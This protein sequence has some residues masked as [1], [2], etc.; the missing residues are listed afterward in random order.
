MLIAYGR[1]E[2]MKNVKA[3]VLLFVLVVFCL[4]ISNSAVAQYTVGVKSGNW[5]KYNVSSTYSG[6]TT[7]SGWITITIQSVSGSIISGTIEGSVPGYST[8]PQPFTVN[9]ETGSTT[10]SLPAFMFIP[11]NLNTGSIPPGV[12][13]PLQG[14]TTKNGREA[15][16]ISESLSGTSIY[17]DRATGVL[18]EFSVSYAGTTASII[19]SDTNMWSGGLFG[20][21]FL[22]LD[23]WI[24]IVIIVVI[25]VVI[26]AAALM[27]RKKK[28]PVA[29]APQV[30][31][32]QPPP[33][34]PPPTP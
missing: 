6:Q 27:L 10:G 28:P 18:L 3:K 22:G 4:A 30:Q 19:V 12:G 31:P 29:P 25:F 5:I 33:P 23:W 17:W 13:L 11:A 34:P 7:Q 14:P 21:G 20:P 26:V 32:P 24:W 16:Y 15:L 1:D 9:I 2:I 8:T